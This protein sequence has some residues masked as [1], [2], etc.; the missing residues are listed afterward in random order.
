MKNGLSINVYS[1]NTSMENTAFYSSD[2][3]L[4]VLPQQGNLRIQTEFGLMV[5]GT[6]ELGVIP[7]GVRFAV[8]V[9][10]ISKG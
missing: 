9:D 8:Y 1:C 10:E 3:D 5:L 4:M 6:G 2:G 7:R